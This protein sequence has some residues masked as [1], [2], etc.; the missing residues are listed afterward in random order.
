MKKIVL[1]I[2]LY[3]HMSTMKGQSR[4]KFLSKK[5]KKI[6][7]GETVGLDILSKLSFEDICS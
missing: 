2:G 6:G 5:K 4:F 7:G 1:F 3:C